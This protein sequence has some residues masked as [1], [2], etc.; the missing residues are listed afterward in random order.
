LKANGVTDEQLAD[1]GGDVGRL[2][3]FH[4]ARVRGANLRKPEDIL[5]E[6]GNELVRGFNLRPTMRDNRTYVQ[7][8]RRERGLP[9]REQ[10]EKAAGAADYGRDRASDDFGSLEARRERGRAMRAARRFAPQH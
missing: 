2:A 4:D 7:E 3:A 9:V 10:H 1:V 6:T 5:N 8:L